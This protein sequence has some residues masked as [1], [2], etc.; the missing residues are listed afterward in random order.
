M[1]HDATDPQPHIKPVHWH[2]NTSISLH[3]E[4]IPATV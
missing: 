1:F 3:N 2:E 4:R